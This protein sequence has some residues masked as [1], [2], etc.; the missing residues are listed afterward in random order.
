MV[1]DTKANDISEDINKTLEFLGAF[2]RI[3]IT[4]SD[5]PPLLTF[6]IDNPEPKQEDLSL[7]CRNSSTALSSMKDLPGNEAETSFK[8][9]PEKVNLKFKY[10]DQKDGVITFGGVLLKE[11]YYDC[12]DPKGHSCSIS[13]KPATKNVKQLLK[14]GE[15]LGYDMDVTIVNNEK[16]IF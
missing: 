8:C 7:L 14:V 15:F 6:W 9:R 5:K 10:K 1:K 16:T 13:F 3:S 2:T 4:V 12:T 11:L